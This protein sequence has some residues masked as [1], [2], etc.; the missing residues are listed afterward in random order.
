MCAIIFLEAFKPV[1]QML[2]PKSSSFKLF[3][4]GLVLCIV[5]GNKVLCIVHVLNFIVGGSTA[6]AATLTRCLSPRIPST[7]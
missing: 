5:F 3:S 2:M 1:V 4:C 7:D 6:A